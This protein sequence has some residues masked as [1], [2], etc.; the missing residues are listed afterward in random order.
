MEA[1]RR[2]FYEEELKNEFK[3]ERANDTNI[4]QLKVGLRFKIFLKLNL[5]N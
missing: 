4:G 1:K 3:K 2:N 5:F